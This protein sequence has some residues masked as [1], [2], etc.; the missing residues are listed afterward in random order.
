MAT[1]SNK[2]SRKL[3][4]LRK[5]LLASYDAEDLHQLRVAM[6]RIRSLLK[7]L[8]GGKARR[9]RRA[10]GE[11][12]ATT[13]AA[14]DWDT[15]FSYAGDTLLPA[16]FDQLR[17][18]LEQHREVTHQWVIAMLQSQQWQDASKHL[19]ET[20]RVAKK[21][22]SA[23]RIG[24]Q[25]FVR[26]IHKVNA[27]GRKALA[28]DDDRRWH[29]LRIRIKELRYTVDRLGGQLPERQSQ[30]TLEHCKRLQEQLGGWHDTVIHR[31]LLDT[32]PAAAQ[33]GAGPE[34]AAVSALQAALEQRGQQCLETSRMIVA[35]P[36]PLPD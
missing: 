19:R 28:A 35:S 8:P 17:P 14:R 15:L 24:R 21:Q 25:E 33:G 13:N 10:W 2:L 23:P 22:R 16:Q 27:A 29:K 9:L 12:A 34:A 4:K 3:R 11:L 1:D 5:R 30:T 31:L 6:R 20:E 32:Y 26:A 7:Q 36:L 18:W